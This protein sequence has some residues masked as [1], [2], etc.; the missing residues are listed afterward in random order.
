MGKVMKKSMVYLCTAV[1]LIMVS[2]TLAGCSKGADTKAGTAPQEG[3]VVSSYPEKPINWYVGVMAGT[4]ID[5]SARKLAVLLEKELGQPITIINIEGGGQNIMYTK[6]KGEKP[7][8]YTIFSQQS[9]MPMNY[10]MGTS[11]ITYKDFDNICS[12]IASDPALM[13]RRDSPLK[14]MDDFIKAAK[15]NPGNVSVGLGSA[16]SPWLTTIDSLHRDLG[17]TVNVVKASKGAVE[18]TQQLLGGHIDTMMNVMTASPGLI[19]SGDV[20]V[21]ALD[22]DQRHPVYPDIPLFKEYGINDFNH[23]VTGVSAPKGLPQDVK[24]K[25][26]KAFAKILQDPGWQE[27]VNTSLNAEF[28]LTGDEYDAFLAK[29]HETKLEGLKKVGLYK[30]KD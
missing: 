27:F 13:V 16:T 30:R 8:G 20:R 23:L 18:S 4:S 24:E 2:V 17:I 6:V 10:G 1:L 22:A 3:P 21:L 29:E 5:T 11:D 25:L 19:E 12:F 26:N 7:D 9:I 15:E 28:Y 14:T